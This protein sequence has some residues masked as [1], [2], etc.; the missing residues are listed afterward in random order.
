MHNSAKLGQELFSV[1]TGSHND[2]SNNTGY[3]IGQLVGL[4]NGM[5]Y[6]QSMQGFYS[7]KKPVHN[8]LT[9]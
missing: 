9:G 5:W 8:C 6:L 2:T 4:G 3:L 1:S 7:G